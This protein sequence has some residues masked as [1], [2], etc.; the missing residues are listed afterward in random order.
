M[1]PQNLTS[2]YDLVC[3]NWST[4]REIHLYHMK[5]VAQSS[6]LAILT[7]RGRLDPR[8]R[9][10]CPAEPRKAA[11]KRSLSVRQLAGP[12]SHGLL[13]PDSFPTWPALAGGPDLSWPA[14]AR[15]FPDMAGF[16]SEN[17]RN[18][19]IA[20]LNGGGCVKWATGFGRREDCG[21][22]PLEPPLGARP[23]EL[24]FQRASWEAVSLE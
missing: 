14:Q 3:L 8:W 16:G 22:P 1:S 12:T 17:R 7:R 10:H 11:S 19:S 13:R 15:F 23:C 24:T 6:A 4:H 18:G 2:R 9:L 21:S 20:S 5:D